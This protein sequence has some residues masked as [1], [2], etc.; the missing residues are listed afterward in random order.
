ML[1]FLN[2]PEGASLESHLSKLSAKYPRSAFER[3]MVDFLRAAARLLGDP[4]LA[5]YDAIAEDRERNSSDLH[6]H[7]GGVKARVVEDR[8]LGDRSGTPV[9]GAIS[10]STAREADPHALDQFFTI[11]SDDLYAA[12]TMHGA[13]SS[14]VARATAAAEAA[15]AAEEQGVSRAASD[16]E[17][18][19]DD[20]DVDVMDADEDGRALMGLLRDEMSSRGRGLK[21]SAP[22]A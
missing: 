7:R 5:R 8:Q 10:G 3:A 22:W 11:A 18:D 12:S 19:D 4:T 6:H 9:P 17:G 15:A 2:V 16:D 21:R 1:Q 14:A 20:Q 13:S